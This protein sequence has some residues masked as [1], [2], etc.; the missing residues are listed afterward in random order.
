M[1]QKLFLDTILVFSKYIP[2][3]YDVVRP[4]YFDN[5][6]LKMIYK[7][8]V[9]VYMEGK[10][11][12]IWSVKE[13]LLANNMALPDTLAVLETIGT[14]PSLPNI[15]QFADK[16]YQDFLS[17]QTEAKLIN[18]IEDIKKLDAGR[19]YD[20]LKYDLDTLMD[21]RT[22]PARDLSEIIETG[23]TYRRALA[24]GK[25]KKSI[26]TI[27]I[28]KDCLP[29]LTRKNYVFIISYVRTGKT[30]LA[31]DLS[32]NLIKN[33]DKGI[34]FTLESNADNLANRFISQMCDVSYKYIED[35][36]A[37]GNPILEDKYKRGKQELIAYQDNF[38]IRDDV[39]ELESIF[40]Y[41]I[42]QKRKNGLDFIVID[43]LGLLDFKGQEEYKA[44]TEISKRIAKFKKQH[45]L[46]VIAL[47]QIPNSFLNSDRNPNMIPGKSSGQ[48]AA[49]CDIAI[50]LERQDYKERIAK[51]HIMKNK[52][53]GKVLTGDIYYSKHW[54]TFIS[55][56][57]FG[58]ETLHND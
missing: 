21:S 29:F 3:Y 16:I 43:Y 51:L 40:N 10:E 35:T 28:L 2:E 1:A 53:M 6:H 26:I 36:S 7:A 50:F 11:P 23:E 14:Q 9:G 41:A 18:A 45:D 55:L 39:F 31:I 27:P 32:V 22:N 25:I 58:T 15:R 12:E 56:E 37:F 34:Y 33:G 13:Y 20:Q 4:E 30:T 19:V 54:N 24:D 42:F 17:R 49:D 47:Q 46:N 38:I 57:E 5:V 8:I 44:L 48:M 52:L